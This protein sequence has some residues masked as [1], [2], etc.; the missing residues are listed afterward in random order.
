[1]TNFMHIY[2]FYQKF[3]VHTHRMSIVDYNAII[4]NL[5]SLQ[6]KI[7]IMFAAAMY[8]ENWKENLIIK[9]KLIKTKL[10]LYIQRIYSIEA[11]LNVLKNVTVDWLNWAA[12]ILIVQIL[13]IN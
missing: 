10:L 13:K 6:E 1:M 12:A 8:G 4:E 3:F 5:I 2:K 7:F 11:S 9:L